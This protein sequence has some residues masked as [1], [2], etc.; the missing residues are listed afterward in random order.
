MRTSSIV[1]II[2]LIIILGGGW[3]LLKHG[4]EEPSTATGPS[5]AMGIN[6]SPNQGNLGGAD[7]GLPQQPQ[8]DGTTVGQNLI[9]GMNVDTKLGTYLSAYNGMTVYTYAKDSVG[10]STCYG[11]C[12]ANWPP[13]TVPSKSDINVPATI[14]GKVD[15]IARADG[16]LQVT[17]NGM[18]LYFWKND[19][20]P[21]DTTGEGVG[22]V[23]H[24][25]KQ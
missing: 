22:G 13:Y 2:V 1:W 6:G 25:A 21:G 24:V 5:Q 23:W 10:T 18:P 14:T 17:L 3:Y 7:T 11:Q 19:A 8:G 16:T 4:S 9:L 15:A 20:K 12:A